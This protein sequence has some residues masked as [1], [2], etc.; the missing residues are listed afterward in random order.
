MK[1]TPR[2]KQQ[3]KFK[4]KNGNNNDEKNTNK[5]YKNVKSYRD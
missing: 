2:E 4:K 1:N 3:L 5:Y